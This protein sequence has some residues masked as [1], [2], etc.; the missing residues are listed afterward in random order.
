LAN[1]NFIKEWAYAGF[2]IVFISA[3]ITHGVV[4]GAGAAINLIVC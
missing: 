3:S 4:Q 1:Y 2:A